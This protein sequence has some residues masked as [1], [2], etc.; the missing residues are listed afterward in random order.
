[1]VN[2]AK[3]RGFAPTDEI[4]HLYQ[5]AHSL[6]KDDL[7]YVPSA[8]DLKHGWRGSPSEELEQIRDRLYSLTDSRPWLTHVLDLDYFGGLSPQHDGHGLAWRDAIKAALKERRR[9]ARTG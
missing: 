9:R 2:K 6:E 5:R 4:L 1:V 8:Y 7:A 3:E